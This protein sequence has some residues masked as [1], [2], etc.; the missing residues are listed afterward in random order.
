MTALAERDNNQ[1]LSL[2]TITH[3]RNTAQTNAK[4]NSAAR[5]SDAQRWPGIQH[6]T[7]VAIDLAIG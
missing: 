2:Y 6:Q 4:R 1:K 3:R 5:M 7:T